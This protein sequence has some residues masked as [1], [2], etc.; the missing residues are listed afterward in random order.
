ML[1]QQQK[2]SLVLAV[3]YCTPLMLSERKILRSHR[4]GMW[5]RFLAHLFGYFILFIT[6]IPLAFVIARHPAVSFFLVVLF[7]F[8]VLY[9]CYLYI[10][11]HPLG[12]P[13][14]VALDYT[15]QLI[16][17][18]NDHDPSV[19]EFILDTPE[20]LVPFQ[21]VSRVL[22]NPY[23]SVFFRTIH[24]VSLYFGDHRVKFVALHSEE[25]CD[26]LL[27]A[28]SAAGVRILRLK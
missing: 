16:L 10:N 9:A 19:Q 23:R 1:L 18:P 5:F 4:Q 7:F 24:R 21:E 22:Y 8:V 25:E 2:F 27:A 14:Q 12:Y 28:L 13:K 15:K 11:E 26:E 17:L 3:V 6:L 20:P